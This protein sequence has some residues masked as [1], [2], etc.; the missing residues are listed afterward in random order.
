MEGISAYHVEWNE[1][2]KVKMLFVQ[3]EMNGIIKANM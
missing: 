2:L 3:L 1:S